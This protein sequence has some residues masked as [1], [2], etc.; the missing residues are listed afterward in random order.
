[1]TTTTQ[2][3]PLN[4]LIHSDANVRATGKVDNIEGL[5][6]SIAA[7]GLRQ[8]LNVLPRADGRSFAV[9]AGGRR[10]RA[11]K[12]LVKTGQ[13]PKDAPIP[14]SCWPQA[15]MPPRSASPRTSCARLCI[16]TTSAPAS[17]P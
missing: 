14:A 1:M 7:H 16:P 8:N 11:L 12:H 9:V 6:A 4:R 2:T 10:L 3:V 17:P 15:T 5:A 13:L